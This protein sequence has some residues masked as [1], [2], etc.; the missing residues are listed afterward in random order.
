[1]GVYTIRLPDVGEGVAEAEL[2]KWHVK[3]GDIVREDDLIA[4]VMTDKASIE[5]PSHVTGKV[6]WLGGEVGETLPIGSDLARIE[7]E[8]AGNT[9]AD[10]N[11]P[12]QPDSKP[13]QDEPQALE[14]PRPDP[15]QPEPAPEAAAPKTPVPRTA[16]RRKEGERPLAPPSVRRRAREAGVDLRRVMGSGPAGRITHDDLT[17]FLEHGPAQDVDARR[18]DPSVFEE[19]LIGLRK[20]IAERMAL[21]KARIPHITIVEEIDMTDLETL[22]SKLNADHAETRGKLTILPF[23]MQAITEAV[24]EQ[25]QINA[26]FDDESGIMR[27]FGGV[28][29]GVATQTPGGLMV[30]VVRHVEALTL[31][32]SARELA[33]LS[34][35]ARDGS[36]G[37]EDLRG[38]TITITSLGPL[39]GI[40]S[41]PIINYPEVAIVGINKLATRPMWDGSGFVPRRM[42]NLSCGFDH[43]VIDGW[44]AA[45]FVQKLKTLLET[46]ALLFLKG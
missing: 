30:P 39:G 45:V 8:G 35:S 46:P 14:K 1:M 5:I 4:E 42:M 9:A 23:V 19:K 43:R 20:K 36:A 34:Q 16:P 18:P 37:R 21:S 33:R 25:P 11:A 12:P 22:R 17:V 7:V 27:R 31:W 3:T 40:V 13:P 10:K 6:L 2:T 28:H 41:T 38:S 15:P 44:D 24:A 26:H 32:E 29:C